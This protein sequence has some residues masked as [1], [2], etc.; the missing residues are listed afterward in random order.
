MENTRVAGRPSA[1]PSASAGDLTHLCNHKRKL[2]ATLAANSGSGGGPGEAGQVQAQALH[3]APAGQDAAGA[4]AG[5]A[6]PQDVPAGQG[7]PQAAPQAA[8]ANPHL[9]R[10]VPD[11]ALGAHHRT[12]QAPPPQ[13]LHAVGPPQA[14]QG[15]PPEGV[16]QGVPQ[17][18][19]A[20]YLGPQ[21]MT[22]AVPAGSGPSANHGTDA[23]QETSA[24]SGM[25]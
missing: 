1:P 24:K 16:A 20:A 14:Q 4:G 15:V 8:G 12:P 13:A 11:V 7:V 10:G 6:A 3:G 22:T 21:V 18:A 9:L 2:V 25:I 5:A 17:G 19:Q 23:F